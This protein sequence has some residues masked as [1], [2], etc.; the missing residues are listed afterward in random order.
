M[1]KI[2]ISILGTEKQAYEFESVEDVK[3]FWPTYDDF[4]QTRPVE[5]R[6]E[7]DGE[8]SRACI[9]PKDARGIKQFHS[10]DCS[11]CNPARS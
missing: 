2:S 9:C 10:N 3:K 7:P 11:V 5:L 8:H 6:N 4:L 1:I